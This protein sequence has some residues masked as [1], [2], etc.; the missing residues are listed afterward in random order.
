MK[1]VGEFPEKWSELKPTTPF[2]ELPILEVP[3]V[4]TIGHEIAILNYIGSTSQEMRGA[5]DKEFAVSQQLLFQ[6]EDMYKKMA[7][8]CD[9]IMV[10]DK[11]PQERLRAFWED[12]DATKHCKDF[13]IRVLLNHLET[14]YRSCGVHTSQP[15]QFTVSGISVGEC[16]LFTTLHMLKLMKAD[17]LAK[18]VGLTEFYSRFAALKKTKDVLEKGGKMPGPFTQYFV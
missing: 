6:S 5:T 17:I 14:F 4:G 3:D 10:K 16:K 11:V 8:V 7:D 2:G 18:Y 12:A 13:G 9:T 15:G 1:W